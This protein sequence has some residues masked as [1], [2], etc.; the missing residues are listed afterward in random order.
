ML[1]RWLLHSTGGINWRE[2]FLCWPNKISLSRRLRSIF[3]DR[4]LHLLRRVYENRS[5]TTPPFLYYTHFRCINTYRKIMCI[6][7][8]WPREFALS[9]EDTH[10][11]HYGI[12]FIFL[13]I[14]SP[15]SLV[16]SFKMDDSG[17]D[18]FFW[19]KF[20]RV[21]EAGRGK[22]PFVTPKKEH[23]HK[24]KHGIGAIFIPKLPTHT[25]DTQSG[26][27]SSSVS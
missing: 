24:K 11:S 14:F 12:V 20:E 25:H 23:T 4:F 17:A 27:D 2:F 5:R 18:V 9:N 21:L 3:A 1:C 10:K 26:S 13:F 16:F 8:Y 19:C 15:Y 6:L 22:K 7:G